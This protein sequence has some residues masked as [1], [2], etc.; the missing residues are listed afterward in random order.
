MSEAAGVCLAGGMA[1]APLRE[2]IEQHLALL[3]RQLTVEVC[4]ALEQS[5]GV[6]PPLLPHVALVPL[7]PPAKEFDAKVAASTDLPDSIFR[8]RPR[9]CV[10]AGSLRDFVDYNN[11]YHYDI[12][13][14]SKLSSPKGT[15]DIF[16]MSKDNFM[17]SAML[18]RAKVSFLDLAGSIGPNRFVVLDGSVSK[19]MARGPN[20]LSPPFRCLTGLLSALSLQKV[21]SLERKNR[22]LASDRLR[23]DK[24][25]KD[26]ARD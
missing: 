15:R 25:P 20:P 9:G 16:K 17:W 8:I 6:D 7:T 22:Q 5:L 21:V 1:A 26:G 12:V 11:T 3:T 24:V 18:S 2:V 19:Y 10:V 4:L 14:P 23:Y 13:D